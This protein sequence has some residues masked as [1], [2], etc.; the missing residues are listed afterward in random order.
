MRNFSQNV[1][2]LSIFISI[3]SVG[4]VYSATSNELYRDIKSHTTTTSNSKDVFPINRY[5]ENYLERTLNI[6][7]DYPNNLDSLKTTAFKT[8]LD[9]K[10]DIDASNM[11][12]NTIYSIA[13]INSFSS[14]AGLADSLLLYSKIPLIY[15]FNQNHYLNFNLT[16]NL[17]K[18]TTESDTMK[19]GVNSAMLINSFLHPYNFIKPIDMSVE[20]WNKHLSITWSMIAQHS[21]SYKILHNSLKERLIFENLGKDLSASNDNT[22]EEDTSYF[23]LLE[24]QATRRLR[25]Q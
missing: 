10:N 16:L 11:T 2:I 23:E 13:S 12:L 21:I 1:L 20:D 15:P 5:L 8:L 24:Y 19:T 7:R 3:I 6:P 9:T 22:I 14:S 4:N 17:D 25:S 18:Y